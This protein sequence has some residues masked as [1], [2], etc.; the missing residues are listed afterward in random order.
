MNPE[1]LNRISKGSF[2][3][4]LN[5]E[6]TELSEGSIKAIMKITP[7]LYQPAGVVHGGALISLAET[8]GSAGSFAMTDPEKFVVLGSAVNSQH[9]APARS[10]K[11]HG[12]GK[13]IV[14]KEFR[15]IWDIEIRDDSGTLV[16]ISRVSNSIKPKQ[17]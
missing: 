9:L 15:H 17:P 10:G 7:D 13:M 8:L 16:S 3:D 1:E 14:K 6:F 12:E 5:I 2:I 11:L 4:L